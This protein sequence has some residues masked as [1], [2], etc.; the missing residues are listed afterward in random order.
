MKKLTL[1]LFAFSL[2]FTSSLYAQMGRMS[3]PA[4]NSAMAKLFGDNP[5]FSADIEIQTGSGMTMPGKMTVGSGKSRFEMNISEAKGGQMSP[6]TAE[7]MKAMGMDKTITIS[8]PDTKVVYIIYP[9][10]SAYVS[11]A[12]QDPDAGKPD[13]AFKVDKSEL[14]RETVDGHP[15]IKNKVVVTDDKG[16]SHESTVWNATDLKDFPVKIVTAE[17]GNQF[18]MLFKNV[19]TAKPDAAQFEAPSDYKKYDNQQSLMMEE[20]KKHMGGMTMPS[21]HP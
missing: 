14:G 19:N 7:H 18:T 15:C 4:Y 8:R 9:G 1:T 13:S 5:A 12:V 3:G 10:L 16:K 17:G 11:M 2:V 20:M 21:G 6:A